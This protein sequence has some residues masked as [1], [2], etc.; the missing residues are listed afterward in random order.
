MK[1]S[2]HIIYDRIITMDS[3]LIATEDILF[4]LSGV[5]HYL[6]SSQILYENL[7][8]IIKADQLSSLTYSANL[9]FICLG[10]IDKSLINDKWSIIIMPTTNND[11]D[12]LFGKIQDIFEEYN[13]WINDINNRI[14]NWD[15]LQSILDRSSIYL[16]NPFALFDNGQG[17]LMT[18]GNLSL[19]K[20]DSIWSYVLQKGYSF[21]ETEGGFLQHK[22][23]M[24]H[25]PFYYNSP[26]IHSSINRLI[27]PIIVRNSFFGVLA[28]T[29]LISPLSKS[30]YANLCLVQEII[31]NTLKITDEYFLNSDT[32]WYIYNL[33]TEKHVDYNVV[34][35]H[36]GLSGKKVE[37]KFFLW[38]FS[39]SNNNTDEDFRIQSYL[40]HLS[41]IFKSS[42]TFYH[43]NMILVC[44]YNLSNYQ[45]LHFEN[46]ILDFL[47]RTNLKA[48]ISMI[49]NNIF[50]ISY[51][52]N[53]CQISNE[54][55]GEKNSQII[56][57]NEIYFNY[58]LSIIE[59]DTK[60]DF[61]VASQIRI[62][63]S[64][65]PYNRELLL[66]LQTFIIN[67]KNITTTAKALNIHRHT[68]VYRLN[69]ISQITGINFEQLDENTMFQL[70]LSCR[71]LL[72]NPL[73]FDK[74]KLNI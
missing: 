44:D 74:N 21:K 9:N 45:D 43:E 22:V 11:A 1:L 28:M 66:T 55:H 70:Y 53:Q 62:L 61:L 12:N 10:D 4:N 65:V 50:E 13:E 16:K 69:N 20:L 64:N 41:K 5:R 6:D 47:T 48:S 40:H 17:L 73:S 54:F 67:G 68:V 34:S 26:D 60:L 52:F 58:I 15:S 72:R 31:Q 24:S 56:S 63:D 2:I 30:E 19:N 36:L 29:E 14:F 38:C 39:P 33:I 7:I 35:Y 42:I 71:I 23:K 46:L 8:Y 27:A 51:A 18:T 57:F 32:P 25:K 59:K 37:D 3:Q 49:F